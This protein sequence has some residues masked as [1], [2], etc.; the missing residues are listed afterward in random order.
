MAQAK[1]TPSEGHVCPLCDLLTR[2]SFLLPSLG[3]K[4]LWV[5]AS[6]NPVSQAWRER[7]KSFLHQSSAPASRQY[8]SQPG[9][10]TG[11][12][13][14]HSA[15]PGIL[16]C[17]HSTQDD[18]L[19][20]SS[21]LPTRPPR[22]PASS[23]STQSPLSHP[24]LAE[25]CSAILA[26][27]TH[28]CVSWQWGSLDIPVG[29]SFHLRNSLFRACVCTSACV[30]RYMCTQVEAR[31][32]GQ[33][34]LS[35]ALYLMGFFFNMHK[36]V[37]TCSN[38]W[39]ACH[40]VCVHYVPMHAEAGGWHSCLSWSLSTLCFD[41]NLSLESKVS[42]PA[43]VARQLALTLPCLQLPCTGMTEQLS[44]SSGTYM[45]AADLNLG[46]HACSTS[47]L[48]SEPYPSPWCWDESYH[49]RPR[50]ESLTVLHDN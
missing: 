24:V 49:A 3:Q 25:W 2:D 44:H 34:F 6:G 12:S 48:L 8:S 45:G 39:G 5:H 36:G 28:G 9:P 10:S 22:T 43:S 40:A 33:M 16:P 23:P 14:Q 27:V 15:A 11:Y 41:L 35:I 30:Y 37:H 4:H 19:R 29:G 46:L 20:A 47:S 31:C 17:S 13:S 21:D 50:T 32:Q 18:F 42:Q 38:V 7:P 26:S 1:A